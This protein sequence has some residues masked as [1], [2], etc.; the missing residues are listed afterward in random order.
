MNNSVHFQ[1]KL[2]IE[3]KMR[4]TLILTH[5]GIKTSDHAYFDQP[6]CNKPRMLR[7]IYAKSLHEPVLY[8]Q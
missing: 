1:S 4:S 5:A 8:L 7:I 6:S 3:M 2:D